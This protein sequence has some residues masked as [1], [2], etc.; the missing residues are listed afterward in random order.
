MK[1]YG[2]HNPGAERDLLLAWSI[3]SPSS[4]STVVITGKEMLIGSSSGISDSETAVKI[5]VRRAVA[6][7]NKDQLQKSVGCGKSLTPG[8]VDALIDAGVRAVL[9]NDNNLC[10]GIIHGLC[11]ARGVSLYKLLR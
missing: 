8:A 7:G 2:D 4:E 5:A 11:A 6:A 1:V 9:I 3:C 10:E